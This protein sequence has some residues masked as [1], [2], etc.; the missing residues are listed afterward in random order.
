MVRRIRVLI[1]AMLVGL[2][3]PAA[4]V[5][6][7]KSL[8]HY[9]RATAALRQGRPRIA[10][11]ELL[12]AIKADPANGA[13]HLMQG[14]VYLQLGQGVAAESEI[15]RAR[16]TGVA[17]G[18]TRHLMAH[19]LWL[20]GASQRALAEASAPDVVPR[21]AGLAARMRGR[22]LVQLGDPQG[23]ATEFA[24]AT[25]LS[26]DN[27]DVWVDFGRFEATRG[28]AA[29]ALLA[30]DRAVGLDRRNV[31]AL[32]LKGA[33]ARTQYGLLAGLTWFDR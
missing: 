2:G 21:F 20:Q 5:D 17:I 7:P 29:A 12:N 22:A 30:A 9:A 1:A 24:R 8:D 31:E 14:L 13:A 27:P 15:A 11:V 23:A 33:L 28:H 6:R 19:A 18:G 16:A 26:P 4:A 25:R 32:I 3:A 10:R